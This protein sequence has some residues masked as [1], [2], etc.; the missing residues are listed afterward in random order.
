MRRTVVTLVA[1]VV[2]ACLA[3]CGSGGSGGSGPGSGGAAGGTA[4][5]SSSGPISGNL[6]VLAAASLTES[7]TTLG[8]QFEAAHP[9]VKVTFGFAASSALAGQITSGAPADVF[10]SASTTT[11][12]AVVAA[13]AATDPHPFAQNVMEIAVPPANPGRVTGLGDLASAAVKT[14][15]CQPQVP[16]GSTARKVFANAKVTVTPV[17]LEPDVK[18]VLAKVQLGEVD[19]GVVYVTDVLAAGDKVTGVEIPAGVNA[20]TSY[21]IAALTRSANA[22]TAAAFVDYVLSPE[23]ASVL[24]AAG[25]HQP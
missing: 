4:S 1:A 14:A 11:M 22:T 5:T 24:T 7:F 17:T 13:G 19:A 21:P 6:T 23:G 12:D 10:A 9:G 18:S 16:C 3:G 20:A 25:F 8:R 2:G 15:V